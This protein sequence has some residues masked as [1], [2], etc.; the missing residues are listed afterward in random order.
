VR[1]INHIHAT[2]ASCN[3]PVSLLHV[4]FLCNANSC[5]TTYCVLTKQCAALFC[6]DREIRH[7]L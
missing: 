1:N 4:E 3:V 6:D 7:H 5:S 2:N